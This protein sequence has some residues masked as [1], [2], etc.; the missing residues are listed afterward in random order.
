MKRVEDF[1]RDI[2]AHWGALAAP[3]VRLRIIGSAAL[4]LQTDYQ[5]GTKDSDVL[6][7]AE[8]KGSTA[9]RLTELAG[10]GT[11]LSLRHRMYVDIVGSALPFMPQ[12]PTWRRLDSLSQ[13]LKHL[14]VEALDVTDVVVSKLKRFLP[15]D[16]ADIVAMIERD[17]VAHEALIERFR[18]AVDSY[19]LDA[20]AEDLPRYVNNLH[21]AEREHE[22]RPRRG[23]K[24]EVHP[25]HRRQPQGQRG[26][27]GRTEPQPAGGRRH[28]VF[29]PKSDARL[30][31][32]DGGGPAF[33]RH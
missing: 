29:L 1:F 32:D 8:L 16:R 21:R 27:H 17:L 14:E 9:A 11:H 22:P 7:T 30:H 3:R 20:R 12:E 31:L 10:K 4:L 28:Q 24:R 18:S 13:T 6:E 25:V 26:D 15:H 23:V 33:S 2:D 19:L 5:R